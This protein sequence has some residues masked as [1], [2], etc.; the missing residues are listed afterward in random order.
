[1][2]DQWLERLNSLWKLTQ[3]H[4]THPC[5]QLSLWYERRLRILLGECRKSSLSL[6]RLFLFEQ[7]HAP[8]E[9]GSADIVWWCLDQGFQTSFFFW[10]ILECRLILQ[11]L[12]CEL[13]LL[14]ITFDH[15]IIQVHG[16]VTFVGHMMNTSQQ[17]L[18][19]NAKHWVSKRSQLAD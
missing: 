13:L 2:G 10:L 5:S 6:S 14:V 8:V 4:L 11:G 18:S 12:L 1:M 19:V 15:R 3:F 17:V 16:F 9:A 7:Q